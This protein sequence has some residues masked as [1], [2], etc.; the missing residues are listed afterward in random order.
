MLKKLIQDIENL[1]KFYTDK[2][3]KNKL[4][5]ARYL[6]SEYFELENIYEQ[7]RNMAVWKV[8]SHIILAVILYICTQID[9]FISK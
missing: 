3:Y 5:S 1:E 7:D 6:S 4:E 2:E 9:K 8:F